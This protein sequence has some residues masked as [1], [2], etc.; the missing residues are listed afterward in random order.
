MGVRFNRKG[1]DGLIDGKAP[2]GRPRLD[3]NQRA[4][5]AGIVES[6]PIPASH[7]LR[8][9][10]LVRG[11]APYEVAAMVAT[12]IDGLT[13]RDTTIGRTTAVPSFFRAGLEV[14]GGRGLTITRFIGSDPAAQN[15]AIA[16]DDVSRGNARCPRDA[17]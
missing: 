2:G 7:D 12:N 8:P 11:V 17:R 14:S 5:L 1:P 13:L 9:A 10:G 3:A 15:P 4:A 16:L 6:G